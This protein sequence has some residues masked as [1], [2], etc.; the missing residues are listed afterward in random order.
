MDGGRR[1]PVWCALAVAAQPPFP[2]RVAVG[3]VCQ[4]GVLVAPLW[5]A[6]FRLFC[7]GFASLTR[8]STGDA[9]KNKGKRTVKGVWIAAKPRLAR[10]S[11]GGGRR[12]ITKARRNITKARRNITASATQHHRKRDA[13]STGA[14]RYPDEKGPHWA[15]LGATLCR[16]GARPLPGA[17]GLAVAC[18]WCCPRSCGR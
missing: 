17:T 11:R 10:V 15:G 6:R 2:Y 12:N 5:G 14:R 8:L 3:P 18:P 13:T 9:G 1:C 7:P 4:M 16:R